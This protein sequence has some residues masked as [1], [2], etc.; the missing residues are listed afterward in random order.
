MQLECPVLSLKSNVFCVVLLALVF[1][2]WCFNAET[3][4]I[5]KS[6]VQQ[7]LKSGPPVGSLVPSFY[8]RAVT[9]PLMNR[10]VCYVCRNGA[11][12]V[13]MVILRKL[14]PG[15]KEILSEI[16][17]V[18]D[19]NRAVGLRSFG[20]YLSPEPTKDI[21]H[22]QTFSFEGMIQM[23]LTIGADFSPGQSKHS[24]HPD[25]GMTI[26]LYRNRKVVENYSFAPGKPSR[27][28]AEALRKGI[29]RLLK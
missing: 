3:A 21:S 2:V 11:R 4:D 18:V 26:V 12:P 5:K 22:V 9:G 27:Q 24:I 28:Q 17:S 15:Y 29:D 7:K 16:D 10:S 25:A 8:V 20:I 23:P 6:E 19:K 13:V 1:P 14:D